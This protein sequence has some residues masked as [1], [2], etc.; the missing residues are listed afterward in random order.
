MVKG[1]AGATKMSWPVDLAVGALY[2]DVL[3]CEDFRHL[4]DGEVGQVMYGMLFV[5]V[6]RR[7]RPS[8]CD[9]ECFGRR[10]HDVDPRRWSLI[11]AVESSL[12]SSALISFVRVVVIV[13]SLFPP[14]YRRLFIAV[15]AHVRSK[16]CACVVWCAESVKPLYVIQYISLRV[17]FYFNELLGFFY[18]NSRVFLL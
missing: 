10:A 8:L 4:V 9:G 12:S 6:L 1:N 11:V 5:R 18:Y 7:G 15:G 14:D 2:V 16:V 17:F 3:V 13:V